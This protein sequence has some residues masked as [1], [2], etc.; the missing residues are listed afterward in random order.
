MDIAVIGLGKLGLPSAAC[1]ASK[2]NKVTGVDLN[3]GFVEILNAGGNPVAEP[4]L[5]GLLEKARPNLQFTTDARKI[6]PKTQL[7]LIVVPT[8][9]GDDNKFVNRYVCGALEGLLP[10]IRSGMDE[11][12]YPVVDVVSTVMP[13]S[14]DDVF[15]PLLEKGLNGFCGKDFGLIYNPEFIALGSVV[16][17]FMHP[18]M[19]LV[20]ESDKVAGDVVQRAYESLLGEDQAQKITQRM[21][22]VNAEITKLS[23]NCSLSV[24]ISI[25]N[26]L[27]LLCERFPG[28]DVD[29]V[30]RAIGYDKR[31]G[32]KLMKAGLG[33]GGPCLPRDLRALRTVMPEEYSPYVMQRK[34]NR[35]IRE[36][37]VR[38]ITQNIPAGG[39]IALLGMSYKPGTH[40]IEETESFPIANML[41]ERGYRVVW[42]DPLVSEADFIAAPKAD[43]LKAACERVDAVALLTLDS[44]WQEQNWSAV[45]DGDRVYVVD[46]WRQLRDVSWEKDGVS[47]WGLGLRY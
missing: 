22:F 36:L 42:F 12:I 28:A 33:P 46:C 35:W 30:T 4:G 8:P 47:Y 20:G 10:S 25:A 45:L 27:A 15:K 23:L 18:D 5:D 6:P 34:V 24:K 16:H 2:G 1:F 14:C 3:Q 26:F 17:N 32:S 39:R 43:S 37:V 29:A 11:G 7:Y 41:I 21:S 31:I 40:V 9:S 44:Y 19:L 13:G 38:R